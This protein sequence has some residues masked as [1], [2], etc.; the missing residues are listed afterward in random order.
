MG[1]AD[2]FTCRGC[3]SAPKSPPI[4]D[5]PERAR[6]IERKAEANA[7][8]RTIVEVLPCGEVTNTPMDQPS[9]KPTSHAEGFAVNQVKAKPESKP[10]VKLEQDSEDPRH[11]LV[12]ECFGYEVHRMLTSKAWDERAQAIATVKEVC[13]QN[14]IPEGLGADKFVD[15]C[16]KL[17]LICLHDKVMPIYFDTLELAKYLFGDFF[18]QYN[19]EV[20]NSNLEELLPIII[21]KT[22]ERN[23]RSN[24]GTRQI[25]TYLARS[26]TVGCSPVMAHI[27][28][29]ITNSKEVSAVRGR[30][31]LI[32]HMIDDFGFGKTSTISMQLV[33][34]FVRP[35]LDATDEKVRRAAIEVTV[36][37]YKHKGDRT[38]K[39]ITNVKPA[40][41][42]HLE[43]RFAELAKPAKGSRKHAKSAQ[44]LPA[45]RG[46]PRVKQPPKRDSNSQPCLGGA[47][48]QSF[49]SQNEAPMASDSKQELNNVLKDCSQLFNIGNTM[50]MS[51]LSS[52]AVAAGSLRED[53]PFGEQ[54]FEP[55]QDPHFIG[56]PGNALPG[57]MGMDE[58]MRVARE[59]EHLD[60]DADLMNEIESY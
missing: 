14:R 5:S 31:E 15:G 19:P 1:L 43:Q 11:K 59:M 7:S 4:P 20:I 34:G 37:C 2:I 32:N 13:M 21:G 44:G 55:N 9:P 10:R 17:L 53:P 49:F 38:L 35:H 16:C 57:S 18:V 27:F 30:L 58:G 29:P 23:A 41:L 3:R 60:L 50:V 39:Y 12:L 33:M 28:T 40:L 6:D 51:P 22:A 25:L 26:P 56:S 46:K 42:K 36:N 8:D 52:T 54:N 24:E 47:S 48:N 45:V